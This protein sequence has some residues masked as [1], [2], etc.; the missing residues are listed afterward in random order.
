M[1]IFIE[2]SGNKGKGVVEGS[3][4]QNRCIFIKESGKMGNLMELGF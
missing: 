4:N 2:E 3:I 1:Q